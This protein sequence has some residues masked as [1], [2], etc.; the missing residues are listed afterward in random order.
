M[1]RILLALLF[2]SVTTPLFAQKVAKQRS[3]PYTVSGIMQHT[4]LEGGCWF[5]QT[6]KEKF[7]LTGSPED[8]RKCYVE[9]RL[10]TLRVVDRPFMASTCMLGRRIEIVEVLDTNFHVRDPIIMQHRIV[11]TIHRTSAGCWY[12]RTK[13]GFRYE[14]RPPIPARYRKIGR[15]FDRD[16]RFLEG[17]E[18]TCN[19]NGVILFPL[20]D[21]GRAMPKKY[22]PR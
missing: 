17:S 21:T 4:D 5:L 10:V 12:I 18:G 20:P 2:L 22:D 16:V 8:L 14:M 7:E 15:K 6:K 13:E 9:G 3:Q 1:R 11:G 19:M